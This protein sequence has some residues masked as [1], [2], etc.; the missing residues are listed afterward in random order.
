M[1]KLC[2]F[3]LIVILAGCGAEEKLE[4]KLFVSIEP[5]KFFLEKIVGNQFEIEVMVKPGMSPATYEPLPTQMMQLSKTTLFFSVGVP[6]EKNWLPVI[7]KN[8]E[9]LIIS[10]TQ[11]GIKKRELESIIELEHEAHLGDHDH[12]HE[13]GELDPH[14]W[15]DPVK[16]KTIC[17]N[18][19]SALAEIYPDQKEEFSINLEKLKSALDSLDQSLAKTLAELPSRTFLVFHPSWGYFADRYDLKQMAIEVRGKE[20]NP[21]E[22]SLIIDKVKELEIKKIFVQKQFSAKAAEA[23]AKELNVELIQIDPL[24][25][26]YF[27]NLEEFARA[28]KE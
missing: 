6:F 11:A 2:L 27:T 17:D 28:L 25:Y 21:K 9:N 24:S 26:N 22:L 15:L 7:K 4:N 8:N 3:L 12:H 1:Q 14:I 5:Q 20:P 19:F 10:E 16:A 23:V 13:H 18:M